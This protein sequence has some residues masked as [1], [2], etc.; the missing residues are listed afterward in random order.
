RARL[1][2]PN[3]SRIY[4][5]DL[6][7]SRW[8]ADCTTW[9]CN[10]PT[11]PGIGGDPLE[12]YRTPGRLIGATDWG[13]VQG[14]LRFWRHTPRLAWYSARRFEPACSPENGEM[15]CP[16]AVCGDGLLNYA[17]VCERGPGCSQDCQLEGYEGDK[18]VAGLA[19]SFAPMQLQ[20][21]ADPAAEVIISQAL[22]AAPVGMKSSEGAGLYSTS[23]AGTYGLSWSH[24]YTSRAS[25]RRLGGDL[26]SERQWEGIASGGHGGFANGPRP[27]PWGSTPRSAASV[28]Y[29]LNNRIGSAWLGVTPEG[30]ADLTAH[31]VSYGEWTLADNAGKPSGSNAQN[32]PTSGHNR[33]TWK[34]GPQGDLG[35]FPVRARLVG[36]IYLRSNHRF[37]VARCVWLGSRP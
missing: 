1:Q 6:S 22:A 11:S 20:D 18:P 34:G 31:A 37:G 16:G 7:G 33:A 35:G 19:V 32:G 29:G 24:W 23:S 12:V 10:Y 26:P 36:D 2:P 9:D 21:D 14:Q 30:L 8:R 3:Y 13:G 5:V 4:N 15:V 27:H 25:C 28:Y 17:E